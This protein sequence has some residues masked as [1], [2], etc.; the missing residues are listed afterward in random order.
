[1]ICLR[2]IRF[3]VNAAQTKLRA[4]EEAADADV[5]AVVRMDQA[6]MVAAHP[7]E[8]KVR[9]RVLFLQLSNNST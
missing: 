5:D 8:R 9:K 7:A 2:M 1:M 6:D 4:N 3:T